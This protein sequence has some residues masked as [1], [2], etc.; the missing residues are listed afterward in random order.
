[1]YKKVF[2]LL[3]TILLAS[4]VWAQQD[5]AFSQYYFNLLYVNPGYAGTRDFFSGTM[6]HRSQW[7]GVDG[8]P[9]TQSVSMHSALPKY[10]IGLGLQIYNDQAGPVK[11][12]GF[13][14]TVAYR[15]SLNENTVLSGGLSGSVSSLRISGNNIHIGD[16]T[17]QSFS[18]GSS[19]ALVPDANFGAYLYKSRMFAGVS[20]THLLQTKFRIND[21]SGVQSAKFYRNYYFTGG[22][23]FRVSDIINFRPTALFKYVPSAPMIGEIDATMIFYDRFY[24]GAGFRSSKRMKVSGMDNMMVGMVIVEFLR[25]FRAGYSYDYFLNQPTAFNGGTHEIMLGWDIS[26]TKTKLKNPRYF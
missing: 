26:L 10:N 13:A 19:A 12:T 14:A 6:V 15:L 1:M 21:I 16:Q 22:Y 3:T 7:V 11:N 20:M 9:T 17:D 4:S 18:T 23:V 25:E 5:A 8:A 24:V 2:S